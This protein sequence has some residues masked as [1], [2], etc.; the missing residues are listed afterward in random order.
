ML[1]ASVILAF[2]GWQEMLLIGGVAIL[3]F[4]RRLP[5]VGRSLGLGIIELKKGLRG[6]TDEITSAGEE[7]SR[8]SKGEDEKS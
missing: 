2:F 1:D 7:D 5:E 8:A 3:L 4:G 6:V